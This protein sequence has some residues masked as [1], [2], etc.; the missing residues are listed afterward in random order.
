MIVEVENVNLTNCWRESWTDRNTGEP[1]ESRRAL[2]NKPGEAPMTVSVQEGDFDAL[3]ESIGETG[4]ATLDV[5]FREGQRGRAFL[6]G[7]D[8]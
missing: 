2:L 4:T 3:A 7:F 8:A 6:R 5:D 1:R